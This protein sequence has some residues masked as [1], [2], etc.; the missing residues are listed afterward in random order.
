MKFKLHGILAKNFQANWE[1]DVNSIAEGVRAIDANDSNF[2]PFLYKNRE[3]FKLA[4]FKN[5]KPLSD[6]REVNINS[7]KEDVV[8]IFPTPYGEDEAARMRGYG[9]LGILGGYGMMELGG[10]MAGSDNWFI[11]GAGNILSTL[12][13]VA[14]EV[15]SALLIQGLLQELM[16]DPEPPPTEPE[17]PVLKSTQSFT[18]TNPVNNVVQGAPVPIG[19]GRVLVGSHVISS[20]VLNSRLAAFNK[21]EETIKDSDGKVVG[22]VH[23]DQFTR[24]DG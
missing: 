4:I 13:A 16:P 1:L 7:R 21:V 23:V 6:V 10:Y 5:K 3:E 20:H 9:A 11:R 12:G 19:Y 22:A 8:H 14:M 2:I 15:G 24:K 18:F 17:G